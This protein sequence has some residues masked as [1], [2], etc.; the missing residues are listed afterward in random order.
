M[1]Y[2]TLCEHTNHYTIDVVYVAINLF[3]NVL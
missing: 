1:I 3:D 2:H